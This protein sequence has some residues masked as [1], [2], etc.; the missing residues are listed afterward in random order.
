MEQIRVGVLT[1]HNTAGITI[2]IVSE[3][4]VVNQQIRS[5][6]QQIQVALKFR[7]WIFL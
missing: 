2:L 4:S 6:N 1:A 5:I 3:F 7:S